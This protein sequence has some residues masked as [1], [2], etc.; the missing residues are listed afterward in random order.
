MG[1]LKEALLIEQ[2]ACNSNSFYNWA[3]LNRIEHAAVFQCIS[4]KY[5]ITHTK[6]ID[7]QTILASVSS[8]DFFNGTILIYLPSFQENFISS[9]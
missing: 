2:A 5:V 8:F 6:G 4:N 3:N 1:L 7:A 9:C